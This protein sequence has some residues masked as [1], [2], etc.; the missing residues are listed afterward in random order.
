MLRAMPAAL[1]PAENR[2]YREL[3]AFA[4][5]LAEH[6]ATLLPRFAGGPAAEP[7]ERGEAAARELLA[8]LEP[9]TAA[10][11]LHG[12]PA[13]QGMGASLA[14]QRGVVRDRFLE[15][16]QALRFA[17][18]ELQHLTTL[19][20]YLGSVAGTRRDEELQ[21]FCGRWERKLKRLEGQARKG[22]AALGEDPDAAVEPFDPTGVGR[23]AHSLGY[24]MGTVGEWVDRRVADR[25]R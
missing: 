19:I 21:E 2:G 20:A 6:W 16:N 9:L 11:G 17:L 25:R 18:E 3:Y 12:R 24:A 23:A 4:R 8:E 22:A 1:H 10:R 5:Q 15:R 7:L 13:A 14:K